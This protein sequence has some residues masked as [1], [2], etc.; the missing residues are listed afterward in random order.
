MVDSKKVKVKPGTR[1]K[2]LL[3]KNVKA[4]LETCTDAKAA[5]VRRI[6][7]DTARVGP[8]KAKVGPGEPMD[9]EAEKEKMERKL[10]RSARGIR[11]RGR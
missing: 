5:E 8:R 7:V 1:T 6:M 3:S 2:K 4:G 10:Q 11:T 9:I